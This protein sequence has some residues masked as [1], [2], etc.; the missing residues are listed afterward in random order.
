M[1][2]VIDSDDTPASYFSKDN[3]CLTVNL[4][5]LDLT[6]V[7]LSRL[8]HR[9]GDGEHEV[10]IVLVGWMGDAVFESGRVAEYKVGCALEAR[11]RREDER[12]FQRC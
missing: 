4:V 3:N 5:Q 1:H 9:H 2:V 6:D 10:T 7:S 12:G 11:R 8:A